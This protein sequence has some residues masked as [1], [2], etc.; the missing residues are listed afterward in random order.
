MNR[1]TIND[2]K[3]NANQ[4]DQCHQCAKKIN[5]S[6]HNKSVKIRLIRVIRVP[7]N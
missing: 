6:P 4:S 3:I 5:R 2:E 1:V 7:I